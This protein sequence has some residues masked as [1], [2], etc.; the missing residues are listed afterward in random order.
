[1]SHND[2]RL[3]FPF[4][5]AEDR[6]LS[7]ACHGGRSPVGSYGLSLLHILLTDCVLLFVVRL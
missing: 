5:D 3:S 2:C 7:T 6:S 4:E 1:M